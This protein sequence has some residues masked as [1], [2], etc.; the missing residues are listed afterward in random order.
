V[1]GD[2]TDLR[3]L[4]YRVDNDVVLIFRVT[5]DRR[6]REEYKER[7]RAVVAAI[8]ASPLSSKQRN[9]CAGTLRARLRDSCGKMLD[10]FAGR[11]AG[12]ILT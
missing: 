4:A 12:A 7:V 5:A 3:A 6:K 11:E 1:G 9:S 10:V 8:A 2:E